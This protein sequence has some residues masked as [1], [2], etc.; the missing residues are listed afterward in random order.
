MRFHVC[1]YFLKISEALTEVIAA[2][3]V[4]LKDY[5]RGGSPWIKTVKISILA[6]NLAR[7]ISFG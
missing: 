1:R 2:E 4:A 6:A 5:F 3:R 7:N